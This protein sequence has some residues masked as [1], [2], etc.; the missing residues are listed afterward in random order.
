MDIGAKAAAPKAIGAKSANTVIY[1]HGIGNKPIASILKCQW[2]TALFGTEL[3]DRSR[4][5]YWVNRQFYPEPLKASCASRRQ[6][7][8]RGRRSNHEGDSGHHRRAGR[9]RAGTVE[10]IGVLAKGDQQRAAFLRSIANTMTQNAET[11]HAAFAAQDV[12]AKILPLPPF[13]RRL[14]TRSL[15]RVLLRDVNDFLFDGER[16]DLDGEIADRPSDGRRR[17]LRHHRSQ[18][19]LDDRL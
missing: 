14:I 9:R 10:E 3:G 17:S 13:L 1:I 18:P 2:D 5:A 7:G 4:M 8:A 11:A 16:R 12:S 6:G 15:T 19:R